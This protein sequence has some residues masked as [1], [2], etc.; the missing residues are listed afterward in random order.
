MNVSAYSQ[1]W[2]PNKIKH[3]NKEGL[4]LPFGVMD[5]I[6]FKL[7]ERNSLI[8]LNSTLGE[9][10]STLQDKNYE[11]E[12]KKS[13]LLSENFIDQKQMTAN[14]KRA[15][16]RNGLYLFGG[17]VAVGFVVFALLVN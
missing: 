7:I 13:L 2:Q 10:L 5:T 12:T 11:A 8:G 14:N 15:A 9:L 3:N 4:F 16:R 1:S 6:S 17:G